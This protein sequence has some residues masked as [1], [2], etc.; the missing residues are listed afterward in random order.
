MFT[1]GLNEIKNTT[2]SEELDEVFNY[3]FFF[4][5][6]SVQYPTMAL[7]I[8]LLTVIFVTASAQCDGGS[9]VVNQSTSHSPGGTGTVWLVNASTVSWRMK[10]W[11]VCSVANP[12]RS[13]WKKRGSWPTNRK[14]TAATAVSKPRTLRTRQH[15][16]PRHNPPGHRWHLCHHH[17]SCTITVI[18]H[19]MFPALQCREKPY[20]LVCNT[21]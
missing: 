15:C 1:R 11:T 6:Y 4:F 8:L 20:T 14:P 10:S 19:S 3:I 13:L 12:S 7:Q 18:C 9:F 2:K 21:Q 17:L 5:E 16:H